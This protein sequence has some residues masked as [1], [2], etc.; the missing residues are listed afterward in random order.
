[1][2][3]AADGFANKCLS[4]VVDGRTVQAIASLSSSLGGEDYS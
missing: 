2:H 1:M 3:W 4:T